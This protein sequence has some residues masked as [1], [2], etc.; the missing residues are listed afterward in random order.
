M[1]FSENKDI[2]EVINQG[3][4][5]GNESA[6][7]FFFSLKNYHIMLL[8]LECKILINEEFKILGDIDFIICYQQ[9]QER[10]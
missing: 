4:F 7:L 1:T 10:Q 8:I 2:N 9:L 3:L 5:R 6:L